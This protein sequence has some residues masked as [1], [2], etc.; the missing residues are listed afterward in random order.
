M[1]SEHYK[2]NLLKARLLDFTV[3]CAAFFL[4]CSLLAMNLQPDFLALATLY[5]LVCLCAVHLGKRLLSHDK[6][7]NNSILRMAL[8]N[9]VGLALGSVILFSLQIS[10]PVIAEY[11]IAI[12]LAS[13][14]AFFMLGTISPLIGTKPVVS[15][16]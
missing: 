1:R 7:A 14:M 5:T 3:I 16:P 6:A 9:A 10:I 15:T 12:V 4:S 8:G 11:S 2:N 13:V